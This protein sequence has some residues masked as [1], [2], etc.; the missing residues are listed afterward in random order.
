MSEYIDLRLTAE[1]RAGISQHLE[2]CQGCKALYMETEKICGLLHGL[3]DT[4]VPA[5]LASKIDRIP[6][7]VEQ[8][9]TG[10]FSFRLGWTLAAAA[11]MAAFLIIKPAP[12]GNSSVPSM[13]V[14]ADQTMNDH[15]VELMEVRTLLLP[16]ERSVSDPVQWVRV[17]MSRGVPLDRVSEPYESPTERDVRD[18]EIW[19]EVRRVSVCS[20]RS[21]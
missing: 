8:D 6:W 7:E 10:R 14:V 20:R 5:T 2:K 3:Q 16:E 13:A 18:D 9:G 12:L 21:F 17:P 1:E 4:P 15:S 19:Q 11:A